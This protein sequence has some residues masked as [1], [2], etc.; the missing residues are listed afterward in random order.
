MEL[1]KSTWLSSNSVV[2]SILRASATVLP[3]LGYRR[4]TTNAIAERAGVSIGSLYYHFGNKD[5]IYLQLMETVS[6]CYVK[7]L[8]GWLNAPQAASERQTLAALVEAVV[9]FT[10]DNR[11]LLRRLFSLSPQLGKMEA[12]FNARNQFAD[13]VAQRRLAANPNIDSSEAQIQAFTLVN[14][15]NGVLDNCIYGTSCVYS[16]EQVRTAL[17]RLA[18]NYLQI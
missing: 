9:N 10:F 15:I 8:E 7:H 4:A 1:L 14:A 18:C 13:A 5:A 6:S 3:H 17:F 16:R 12:V 11:E 2:N